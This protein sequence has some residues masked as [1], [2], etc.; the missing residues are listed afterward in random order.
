MISQQMKT[1][2]LVR[3]EFHAKVNGKRGRHGERD[4]K[5]KQIALKLKLKPK[6]R[7]PGEDEE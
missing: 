3:A 5:W 4:A 6:R 1:D 7:E 2:A